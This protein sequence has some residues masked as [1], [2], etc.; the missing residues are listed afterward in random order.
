MRTNKDKESGAH[1]LS[2]KMEVAFYER[3]TVGIFFSDYV[4]QVWKLDYK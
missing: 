4:R 3:P 1:E 2:L